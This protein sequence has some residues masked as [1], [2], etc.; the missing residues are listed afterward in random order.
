MTNNSPGWK[1]QQPGFMDYG[2]NIF[3]KAHPVEPAKP[4]SK[5]LESAYSF[6]QKYGPHRGSGLIGAIR[7]AGLNNLEGAILGIGNS[8]SRIKGPS[9]P[10]RG[11]L[12][13]AIDALRNKAI[14]DMAMGDMMTFVSGGSGGSGGRHGK[15]SGIGGGYGPGDSLIMG[16]MNAMSGLQQQ[17]NIMNPALKTYMRGAMIDGYSV[18]KESWSKNSQN[19]KE[20]YKVDPDAFRKLNFRIEL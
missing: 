17:A 1:H 15:L 8:L 7:G 10:K 4:S 6:N 19:Q 14:G 20:Y 16:Q 11:N 12:S 3:E 5:K 2:M 13:D 18:V 9:K